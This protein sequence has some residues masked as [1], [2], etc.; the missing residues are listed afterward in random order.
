MYVHIMY[1]TYRSCFQPY[2]LRFE[3]QYFLVIDVLQY[4]NMNNEN[5]RYGKF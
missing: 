4:D 2:Y 5:V 3:D 1:R